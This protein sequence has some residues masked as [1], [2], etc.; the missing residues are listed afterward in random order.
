MEGWVRLGCCVSCLVSLL[1]VV[2]MCMRAGAGFTPQT[3]FERR[4]KQRRRCSNRE[5]YSLETRAG[6][7]YSRRVGGSEWES[8]GERYSPSSTLPRCFSFLNAFAFRNVP[9][10]RVNQLRTC[11]QKGEKKIKNRHL[12]LLHDSGREKG[13]Q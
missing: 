3:A 12:N 11:P 7:V 9:V 6:G 13:K 4:V 8:A 10:P 2:S 5:N 1:A